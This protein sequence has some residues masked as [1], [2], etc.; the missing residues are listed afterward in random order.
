MRFLALLL[1]LLAAPSVGRAENTAFKIGV[2]TRDFSPH[3]PYDWRGA[4]THALRAMIWYPAT[5]DSREQPQWVG[6]PVVPFFST[7]TAARDA[8]PAPGPKRP[9]ILLSHGFGGTMTDLAW[10]G[11]ALAAH[12]FI[13]VAIDHPGNNGQD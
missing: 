6:P 1:I 7:G 8:T 3:E 2:T 9:L 4:T 13:A 12:G 10:F 11:S 5:P